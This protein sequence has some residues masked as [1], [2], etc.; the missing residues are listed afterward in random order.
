MPGYLH[1]IN[2]EKKE[3]FNSWVFPGAALATKMFEPSVAYGRLVLILC[4]DDDVA[5]L[6]FEQSVE[7]D[8]LK[9][10]EE[11]DFDDFAREAVDLSPTAV[12][13]PYHPHTTLLTAG[14]DLKGG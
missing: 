11:K 9:D 3:E 2:S 10:Y 12:V 4:L 1:S 8:K 7:T 5:S 6:V 13:T 14:E